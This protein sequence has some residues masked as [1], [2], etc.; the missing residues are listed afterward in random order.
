MGFLSNVTYAFT[1][2]LLAQ[3]SLLAGMMANRILYTG[4]NLGQF[5]IDIIGL[6]LLAVILVLAPLLF[7]APQL[8][9]AKR[10]G[11]REYG[12][13]A[14]RY[15]RE[16]DQKWLRGG[17]DADEPLLGSGDIQSLADM[18]NSY[19]VVA[20]MKWFPFTM[21]TVIHLG[22]ATIA[23]VLPLTLTMVPLDE[24]VNRLLKIIF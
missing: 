10:A 19:Q 3:G 16:F 15:V 4:A 6:V 13:L 22:V 8:G 11:R 2:L 9:R 5:K 18:G 24:I 7:F 12:V 21:K 23:P 20:D 14:Q 1:P 17:A